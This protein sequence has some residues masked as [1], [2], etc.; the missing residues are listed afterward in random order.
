MRRQLYYLALGGFG[1]AGSLAVNAFGGWDTGLQTLLIVMGADYITGIICALLWNK[2]PKSA[3]G[4]FDSKASF[5]GI[6]RK[7]AILLCVLLAVRLDLLT[8]SNLTRDAVILFFTANDGLSTL[9]NL[10]IM[11][12][13][14]PAVIRSAFSKLHESSN[15]PQQK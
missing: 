9:E 8:N 10:G 11:G 4:R 13:P 12:V 3:D 6:L 7:M 15:T 2:S 14:I 5:Q 1:A